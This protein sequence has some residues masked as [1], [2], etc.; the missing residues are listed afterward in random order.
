MRGYRGR[1]DCDGSYRFMVLERDND[2][3]YR[4]MVLERGQ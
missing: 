1:G 2:G 4:F 3:S